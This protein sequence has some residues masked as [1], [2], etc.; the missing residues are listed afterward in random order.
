MGLG[1]RSL[2]LEQKQPVPLSRSRVPKRPDVGRWL[3]SGIRAISCGPYLCPQALAQEPGRAPRLS[4]RAT[5]ADFP[6][7]NCGAPTIAAEPLLKFYRNC[8]FFFLNKFQAAH[9]V[10]SPA[11]LQGLNSWRRGWPHSQR[12]LSKM[13]L[14]PKSKALQGLGWGG[15]RGLPSL[16]D[17][18]LHAEPVRASVIFAAHSPPSPMGPLF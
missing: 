11:G 13:W 8:D 18:Q 9:H 1:S 16:P 3:R 7:R 4:Y 10:F 2:G 6:A 12:L 17:P 14:Q 5:K 15:V